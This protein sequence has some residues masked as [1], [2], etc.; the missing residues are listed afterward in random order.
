MQHRT[1]SELEAEEVTALIF[2]VRRLP[3][4]LTSLGQR[5][6]MSPI[7]ALDLATTTNCYSS[8]QRGL[9]RASGPSAYVTGRCRKSSSTSLSPVSWPPYP[10]G[11]APDILPIWITVLPETVFLFDACN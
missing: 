4:A 6:G 8:R 9:R 11:R 2:C 5:K 10:S 1:A 7:A 3:Q